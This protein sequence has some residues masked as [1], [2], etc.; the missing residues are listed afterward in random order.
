MLDTE[1]AEIALQL[2]C[3]SDLAFGRIIRRTNIGYIVLY[4]NVYDEYL[5]SKLLKC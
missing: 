1:G 3:A 5:R 2:T 4:I